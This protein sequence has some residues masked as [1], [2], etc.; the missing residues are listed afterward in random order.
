LGDFATKSR[1][2]TLPKPTKTF[3]RSLAP[4][5]ALQSENTTEPYPPEGSRRHEPRTPC[6][7]VK[8]HFGPWNLSLAEGKQGF[9]ET[10]LL[11][12]V[13]GRK[14]WVHRVDPPRWGNVFFA[15]HNGFSHELPGPCARAMLCQS[16]GHGNGQGSVKA[17]ALAR[18]LRHSFS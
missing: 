17:I 4:P 18:A 7:W 9:A 2:K 6:A 16:L 15:K 11:G 5:L 3:H 14:G 13:K 1:P 12:G 10:V 8:V